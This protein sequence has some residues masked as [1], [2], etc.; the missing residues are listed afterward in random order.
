M[1]I[2]YNRPEV[3][4]QIS[5][6]LISDYGAIVCT[7]AEAFGYHSLEHVQSV[8][9]NSFEKMRQKWAK[10]GVPQD[11]RSA[12]WIDITE[13]SNKLFCRKIH[14]MSKKR[15]GDRRID[16]SEFHLDFPENQK[17][18][19]SQIDMLF[20]IS[21]LKR[22][23][24]LQ[25][26]L[27]LNILCGFSCSELARIFGKNET[28]LEQK[29]SAAKRELAD[30]MD[31]RGKIKIDSNAI[32]KNISEIFSLGQNGLRK[33]SLPVPSLC[34]SAIRLAEILLAFPNTKKPSIHALLAFM[35]LNASRLKTMR[36][37]NGKPLGIKQQNRDLWDKDMIRRGFEHLSF[38]AESGGEVTEIH[39]KAGVSA[40]HALAKRY[41]DTNWERII[42][43]YDSYLACHHCP[44][45]ELQRAIAIAKTHGAKQGIDAIKEI[46]EVEK[47]SS[48]NLLYST[49]G[50]LNFELHKYQDAISNFDRAIGLTEE[51]FE[52]AFYS[53]K[54]EICKD[55]MSMSRRYR[56]GISF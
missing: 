14:H 32:V 28:H 49:L 40:V 56:Y 48:H 16:I 10:Q 25:K 31:A 34:F 54:I 21:K 2:K 5:K 35:L 42:T 45:V 13:S 37:S 50:N 47:L 43:L 6:Q 15:E 53:R 38:S 41:G 20:T 7:L 19:K 36:D 24:S 26:H 18:L 46:R 39:L 1:G 44:L 9:R 11:P 12:I 8:C 30:R 55:R 17:V 52:K 29:L 3:N 51:T 23:S 22:K 27:I 4:R 33:G